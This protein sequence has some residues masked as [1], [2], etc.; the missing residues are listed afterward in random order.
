MDEKL[1]N[2]SE[3]EYFSDDKK[4]EPKP[5]PPPP[6]PEPEVEEESENDDPTGRK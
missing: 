4:E 1:A 6:P 2:L 5:K 3:E